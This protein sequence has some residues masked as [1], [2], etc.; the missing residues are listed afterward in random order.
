MS[1]RKTRSNKLVTKI[2]KRSKGDV[3]SSQSGSDDNLNDNHSSEVVTKPRKRSVTP[4]VRPK[5]NSKVTKVQNKVPVQDDTQSSE[6]ELDY[7]DS[8]Q[9]EQVE[10]T[11]GTNMINMSVSQNHDQTSDNESSSKDEQ[12]ELEDGEVNKIASGARS[13]NNSVDQSPSRKIIQ[14]KQRRQRLQSKLD[15]VSSTLKIMQQMMVKKGFFDEEEQPDQDGKLTEKTKRKPRGGKCDDATD[16]TQISSHSDTT[17]YREA[18]RPESD[19]NRVEVI[20]REIS[21]NIKRKESTSSEDQIDTSDELLDVD[22]FIAD[23][24][25]DA[26]RRSKELTRK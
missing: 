23:C 22:K 14:K 19:T 7:E 2:S 13:D 15:D 11:E 4:D 25:E 1:G 26:R 9:L 10:F 12:S 6:E 5:V 17:I 18:V 16:S 20:D 8:D 21:F 3:N 24:Q